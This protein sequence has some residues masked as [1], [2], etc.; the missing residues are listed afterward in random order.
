MDPTRRFTSR[1]ENYIKYRPGYPPAL[2]RLLAEQHGLTPRSVIADVGSGTGILAR[3]LLEH[4]SEVYGVEPNREMR[5]AGERLLAGF[6]RFHSVDAGAEATTLPDASVDLVTAAQAFHWFDRARARV[7][8]ARMLRPGGTVVLVWNDR[9]LESTPFLA[10]Y[11][12]LLREYGTDYAEVNHTNIT[13]EVIAAFFAGGAL[14]THVLPNEQ[15]F[16]LEGLRGRLL[17]SSYAPEEGHPRH[18]PMLDALAAI[19]DQHQQ[20]GQVAFEYDT[21]VYCGRF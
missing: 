4:G 13:D 11:E 16:D 19:F 17:S 14:A 15:R 8:F 2:I 7:E 5:E 1:V 6:P 3:M 21:R 10:A 12:R 20:G 18:L 9:R